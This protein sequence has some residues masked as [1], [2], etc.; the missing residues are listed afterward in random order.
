M[1]ATILPSPHVRA[2]ANTGAVIGSALPFHTP[3]TLSKGTK[4]T[5]YAGLTPDIIGEPAIS[6]HKPTKNRFISRG[7]LRY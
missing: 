4:T 5:D 6:F 3:Q 1:K 7:H 2:A